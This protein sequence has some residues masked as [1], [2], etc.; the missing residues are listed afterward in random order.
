MTTDLKPSLRAGSA[1][2]QKTNKTSVL[3]PKKCSRVRFY[4]IVNLS[5]H[6]MSSYYKFNESRYI[7]FEVEV[8][9]FIN[10]LTDYNFNQVSLTKCNLSRCIVFLCHRGYTSPST[11]SP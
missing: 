3:Q 5:G 8:P 9:G 4:I 7:V 6:I 2:K 1:C 11:G 10:E